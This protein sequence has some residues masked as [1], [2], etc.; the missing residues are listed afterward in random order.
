MRYL[1]LALFIGFGIQSFSQDKKE[2]K[3]ADKLFKQEMYEDAMPMYKKFLTIDPTNSEYAYKFGCCLVMLNKNNDKA[4][5]YLLNA[6]K[7]GKTDSEVA[8]FLGRA[9]ENNKDYDN[10]IQYY[11]KFAESADK[12]RIKELKIKKRIKA[13]KKAKKAA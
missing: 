7:Q 13:C 3:E 12:E 11:E 8:Y 5:E 4:I 9:Y 1:V 6:K 10:A 2:V